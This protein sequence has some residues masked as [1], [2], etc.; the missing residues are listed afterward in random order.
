MGDMT[1]NAPE[2]RLVDI[3]GRIVVVKQLKDAQLL[4]LGRDAKKLDD[5]NV[6]ARTKMEVSS[7]VL[8][9]FESAIVQLAD[10]EYVMGLARR[11]EI[12]LKDF[13]EFLTVFS[14]NAEPAKPV[15]RRGRP[16]KSVAK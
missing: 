4:L 5:P 10:R 7:G 6:D 13:L 11:G 14:E 12:E 8:D 2:T 3:K 15:V 16:R 9:M 1:D